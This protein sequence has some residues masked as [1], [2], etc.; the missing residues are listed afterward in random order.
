M[1]FVEV[2]SRRPVTL[3]AMIVFM[4]SDVPPEH[5]QMSRGR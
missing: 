1:E 2:Y 3:R 4:I 5:H